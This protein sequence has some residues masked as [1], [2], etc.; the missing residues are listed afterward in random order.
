[1]NAVW[2]LCLLLGAIDGTT[3]PLPPE[4]LSHII[5]ESL[6]RLLAQHP[7][8]AV[9]H[10]GYLKELARRPDLAETETAWWQASGNR[11]LRNLAARFEE[12]LANDNT[13]Q[14]RF[15]G[16]FESLNRSPELRQ[17]VEN[18]VRTELA[19]V[20]DHPALSGALQFLRANSDIALRF[21]E[22][23]RQVRPLPEPLEPAYA[24]FEAEPRW[25]RSLFEAYDRIAQF[26]DA[27]L[28][29]FPWWRQQAA[30]ENAGQDGN[31]NLDAAL[32]GHSQQYWLWH[33]RNLNLANHEEVAPWIRYWNRLIQRDTDLAREYGPFITRLI[34]NP[35]LLREHLA[36]LQESGPAGSAPWPPK[37]APPTLAPLHIHDPI[38]Q[39]K[40]KIQRP[41]IDRPERPT[42][43]RP[44]V[45]KPTR[46]ESP[47]RP[48]T[49]ARARLETSGNRE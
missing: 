29:V 8:W 3:S 22:N 26:P 43:E 46:P 15:N 34:Q 38:E 1:M 9:H 13:A 18:L 23:P 27:H 4:S 28:T 32:Y 24:A 41:T 5:P 45:G 21:L 11:E 48:G 44:S 49:P 2:A 35:E 42:I 12:A 10:Q 19:H 16:Y 33:L 37:T 31:A 39:A 14:Y 17:A 40:S 30:L 6:T 25:T 7:E 47:Q 36:S 20:R